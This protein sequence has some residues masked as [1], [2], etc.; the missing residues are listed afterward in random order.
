VV[1]LQLLVHDST[2]ERAHCG[3]RPEEGAAEKSVTS[4]SGFDSQCQRADPP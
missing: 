2:P 4:L 1:L 3:V